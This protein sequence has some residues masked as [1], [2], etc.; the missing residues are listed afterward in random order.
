MNSDFL[1]DTEEAKYLF[2]NFAEQLPIIDYHNHLSAKEILQDYRYENITEL[3]LKSDPYKHRAMRMCGVEEHY[4]T[5]DASDFEKFKKWCSVFPKLIG[6]PLYHWS[7]MELTRV[8]NLDIPINSENADILWKDLNEKLKTP[9]YTSKSILSRFNIEYCA[10]CMTINSDISQFEKNKIHS[11]SLRGDDMNNITAEFIRELEDNTGVQISSLDSLKKAI[12]KR[13]EVFHLAG[14]R[15]ADHALD[16][17]FYYKCDDGN[18]NK[19]LQKIIQG[20]ELNVEDMAYLNSELLRIAGNEYALQGWVMQLHIGAMRYT[21]TRLRNAV[22]AAGGFA[23]I[24]RVDTRHI[25]R[26]LDD[27]E[28]GENGIPRTIL[29]TLNPAGN[30][31][32]AILEGS[33]SRDGVSALIQQGPAW[34]WCDHYQG[35]YGMLDSISSFGLLYEFIGMTTDSRSILSFVRHEYFRRVLCVW[36][37]RKVKSGEF[38]ADL[39]F[40][41]TMIERIC[42][43]NAAS[44]A[45]MEA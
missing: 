27:I 36:I 41:G 32:M 35:I 12:H 7:K 15:F 42:Y 43:L 17:N 14:C 4:I 19:R 38:D 3:W 16:D 9:E 30:A 5:G 37:G 18:N 23:G 45:G 21:S 33:Y 8:F 22:G 20:E 34:W 40:L 44:A 28:H 31:E 11:P 29:F 6:N 39:N 26:L 24:G 10:P 1:L 13:C 2:K 25:A